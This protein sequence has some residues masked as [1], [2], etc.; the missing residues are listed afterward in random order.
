MAHERLKRL[1]ERASKRRKRFGNPDPDKA[2]DMPFIDE[3]A[4]LVMSHQRL[5]TPEDEEDD[6]IELGRGCR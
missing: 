6:E 4:L 5:P 1:R 3:V 2:I